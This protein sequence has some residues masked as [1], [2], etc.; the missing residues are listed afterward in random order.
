MLL[1]IGQLVFRSK[2]KITF[3][4]WN[5]ETL[6]RDGRL[7]ELCH[8]LKHYRWNIIG[9][10]EV[11]KKA[12]G[13]ICSDEGHKLFYCGRED[14]HEH[15][16]GFLVHKD[17]TKSVLGC[18]FISSR[19]ISIRIKASP[20]N[21]TL[22]QAYAPTS[23]YSD[24][25]IEI[26]YKDIQENI[27]KTNKKDIKI[28]LGDFNAKIG[29]DTA[30]DWPKQQGPYCNITTND[31]GLRLLEFANYNDFVIA[32]TLGKH[33][34]PRTMTWHHP[35]GVNQ[36]Q[37]DYILVPN[38]F[39]SSVYTGRT[40]TFPRPDIASPHDLVMTTFRVKL[41]RMAKPQYTRLKFDLDKLQDPLIV[42]QF[43]ASIG[44][45]FGPLLLF[46]DSND[47]ETNIETF[48]K[49]TIET[50][51]DILGK[52][53]SKKKPW[54]TSEVLKMC[55]QRRK[56]KVKKKN[57]PCSKQEYNKI[58]RKVKKEMI[59]AKEQWIDNQ[60]KEIE[61]NLKTNNSKKAYDTVKT[62]TK[63]KQS[64]VNSIKNK[65]GDIIMEKSKI[66]ERW[67]EHCS[68]LYN[69]EL[70]GDNRVLN[71]EES[72]N[73][74]SEDIILMS[75]I[76][77]AIKMLKKDKSPGVDN[78]PGEL[79]QAGGEHMATALHNICNQIW[80]NVKWPQSWTR[81][82]VIPLPKKGDLK[83]CNNYRTLSL[84]SHPS[85]VLLRVILNRLKQ[86]AK[87]IIAEEQAGFV[88]GRSTV[89]QIFNL[90]SIIE[91][92]QEHQLELYHVFIDFK[93][94]FDRVWH[95]ALWAT[96]NHYNINKTLIS[97]IEELYN[98]ATSSVYL[99]GDF[100]DW[101]RTTVGVRQG[102]LLSPTL[103]N[104]F[105]ER[106]MTDA[107]EGHDATVSI[108]GRTVSNLRF[109]DD[110][111]G[112][113]G[114]E[115]ELSQL[116]QR[117]NN[118]CS[119][120]GMEISAEK[121]KIM[122]NTHANGLRNDI[123]INGSTLQHVNQFIYLGAI[124]TD[125]GSRSEIL[126]RMAKAQSS[127]SKLKTVWEDKN[128]S[129]SSKIR[130]LRS[131]VISIF[132]YACE[133]WTIDSYLEK[134]ISAFEM[135]CLRQLLGIDPRQ[136]VSNERVRA[137][138]TSEIGRHQDLLEIVKTRKLKWFG[139]TTRGDG[140]AKTCLQGTVRGG[141]AR[142]RP[143]KKWADNISDWTGL[144]FAEATRAAVCREGWR[145]L[146]RT[147]ASSSGPNS[148]SQC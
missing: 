109:A 59:K 87:E 9:L 54:V 135:R 136:R 70:Q 113:A 39:R 126:S 122:T 12:L 49:A 52:K 48:E 140:L 32:N 147:S 65:Q 75:E 81:S 30:K 79:I 78:I 138:V 116:I 62:L 89:E 29:K 112:L 11:R 5:V 43:Q 14:K 57:C 10:S 143:R 114:S 51:T 26:F 125:N 3:G 20:F 61:K 46:D 146:V 123:V 102:C 76:Q 117:L 67:T 133:S 137:M 83:V 107:L 104:V 115:A 13:E 145:G 19:L 36:S 92:Y 84:I 37:I 60:C 6:W 99:E 100:G 69:Y 103:F 4:T 111:D 134:R 66:L 80:K 50:A 118:S 33:K 27:D 74:D 120:F 47:I 28:V 64:K 144:S 139:H 124:V 40:R 31:R 55:D 45:K 58:N 128:I 130:L 77:E 15:G 42:E 8:E 127:L 68:E 24:E 101:F 88:K 129:I 21:I 16:V 73:E 34:K 18:N 86:Q 17:T 142:G 110:I 85:K 121:T 7:E 131:M 95:E 148:T 90:R 94:A 35:N 119:S 1:V 108:G 41:R 56:L 106:I 72:Q 98:Q 141:R 71:T 91:K 44:G 82:L 93:K 23:E 96:M 105:L 25:D 22:F 2:D 38:R 132:L 97:L 53:I 63:P